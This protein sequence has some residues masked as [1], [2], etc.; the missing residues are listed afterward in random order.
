[1]EEEPEQELKSK[2]E[3]EDIGG[4]FNI[5]NEDCRKALTIGAIW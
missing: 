1:L 2:E 3:E 5:S 4:F